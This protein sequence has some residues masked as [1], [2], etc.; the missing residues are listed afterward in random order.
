[1]Q[2]TF[3]LCIF[4]KSGIHSG[5]H[6]YYLI[7]VIFYALNWNLATNSS[8][9]VACADNSSLVA[10]DSSAVAELFCTTSEILLIPSLA[11][12]IDSTCNLILSL[13]SLEVSAIS[14]TDATTSSNTSA[15]FNAALVPMLISFTEPSINSLVLTADLALC[16]ARLRI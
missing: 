13:N 8:I 12:S 5:H 9:L 3:V 1:M 10:E 4:K 6:F 2:Q 11:I 7:Y 14:F 16:S 15:V